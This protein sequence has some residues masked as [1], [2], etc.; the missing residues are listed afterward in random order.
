MV[1]LLER[2]VPGR[3]PPNPS[4]RECI[5]SSLDL[6][7][8]PAKACA[9]KLVFDADT[10]QAIDAITSFLQELLKTRSVEGV[11]FL[12]VRVPRCRPTLSLK[13]FVPLERANDAITDTVNRVMQADAILTASLRP[14]DLQSGLCFVNTKKAGFA[15]KKGDCMENWRGDPTLELLR[16]VAFQRSAMDE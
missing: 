8:A 14:L 12:A 1:S 11:A 10:G 15:S 9:K 16:L 7:H 2:V 3:R 13:V 4:G 6:C 5:V